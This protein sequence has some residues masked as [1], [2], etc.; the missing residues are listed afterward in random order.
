MATCPSCAHGNPE[1]FNS[2]GKCGSPLDAALA[3]PVAEE[4]KIVTSS[5][6]DLVGFTST[7]ES[8][9][10]EDVD[11]M[12]NAYFEMARAQIE[13]HVVGS[14]PAFEDAGEHEPK[15]VPDRWRLYRVTS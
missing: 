14:G 6:C 10:P 5:F 15:G 7:S 12:L 3:R 1:G 11:K 2:C 4:R 9:D 13:S 8:A